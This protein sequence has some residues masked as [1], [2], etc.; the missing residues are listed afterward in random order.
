MTRGRFNVDS[1]IALGAIGA[2]G[3]SIVSTLRQSGPVY[4]ETAC[5]TLV[6]VT[7]GRYL[8]ARARGRAAAALKGLLRE[9]PR[10]VSLLREGILTEVPAAEVRPGDTVRVA[11]GSVVPVDGK[12]LEGEGGVDESSLTGEPL[13]ARRR[14]GDP[15]IAGTLSMDGA[16]LLRATATGEERMAARIGRLLEAARASRAPMEL[17]AD[18][19]A[20]LFLPISIAAA[21]GSGIVWS[22]ARD[23]ATGWLNALAVLLIAC[24]CALGLATPLAVWE[25]MGAA[26]RRG[27]VIRGGDALER[28]ASVKSIFFDKTGTLTRGTPALASC[29][30]A[31]GE[32]EDRA[33]ASAAALE[34]VS[35]HP[36]ARAIRETARDRCLPAGEVRAFRVH[37]GVGVEGEV[38]LPG[39]THR[40]V[41]VGGSEMLRRWGLAAPVWADAY[42]AAA[43]KA[44]AYLLDEHHVA[45]L[46]LFEEAPRP[47]AERALRELE[48]EGLDL[49]ILTGDNA[50]AGEAMGRRLGIRVRSRLDPAGKL[51][52]IRRG[53]LKLGPS[54]MVGEGIN[55]APALAGAALS[56]AV[57]GSDGLAREASDITLLGENLK[58]IPWL[59]KLARRTVRTIRVNLFWAFAYNAVLI[60]LAMAGRLTPVLAALAMIGSSLFVVGN[61]MQLGRAFPESDGTNAAGGAERTGGEA[62]G[63]TRLAE[64]RP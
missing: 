30:V 31:P 47:E 9:E 49:E 27:I 2:F 5:M 6:L 3:F 17:L 7:L 63:R 35:D 10:T 64:A 14:K 38:A 45:A 13:P 28:L 48:R 22:V 37:P 19:I 34:T 46:F 43:G 42:A 11:A 4:Y 18:R 8:E 12:I 1:L 50:A 15:L 33:L 44:A 32:S 36:L 53:E 23:P 21:L 59:V 55:D 61:S 51:E 54:A 60:P 29:R 16:F 39:E 26:V 41:A 25:A 52:A 57:G 62:P 40:K 56:I 58:D 24:P 20:A